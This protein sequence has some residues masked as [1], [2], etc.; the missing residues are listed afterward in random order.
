MRDPRST[1]PA[2]PRHA[3]AK[4][5]VDSYPLLIRYVSVPMQYT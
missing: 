1:T 2:L 4:S 5:P 3:P